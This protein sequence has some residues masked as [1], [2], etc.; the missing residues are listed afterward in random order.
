MSNTIVI[1][2]RKPALIGC[3]KFRLKPGE[4]DVDLS[5]WTKFKD[6][7]FGRMVTQAGYL[8]ERKDLKKATPL[9]ENL[10]AVPVER[11]LVIVEKCPAPHL[12][13]IWARKETRPKVQ[14]AIQR[15]LDRLAEPQEAE[16]APAENGKR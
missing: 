5:E 10:G 14:Q 3:S 6:S 13:K 15:R 16:V 7:K 8:V 9:E 1:E 12:L 11:A 4:N 2:N